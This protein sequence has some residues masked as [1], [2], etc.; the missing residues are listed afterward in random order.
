[1]NKIK[2]IIHTA[3]WHLEPSSYHD[4]FEEA[5]DTFMESIAYN[6]EG[7]SPDEIL[8]VIVGDLFDNKSKKQTNEAVD[9]MSKALNKISQI[10]RTV[11]T[12][13]NHDYDRRNKSSMDC[14]SPIT[15]SFKMLG[16]SNVEYLKK[17]KHYIYENICFFNFSN[18]DDNAAPDIK[19]ISK[20]YPN[21]TY[22]GLYHD[23]LVGATNFQNM[24]VSEY[25]GEAGSLSIFNGCDFVLLGD[26]HKHQK[27][28]SGIPIVYSGSLYQLNMG[29]NV[30]GHGYCIWD[31]ED[32]TFEFIE[33]DIEWGKYKMQMSSFGDIDL[34]NEIIINK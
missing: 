34:N 5:I 13:G 3:D 4:R 17:T 29:E 8:V 32:K 7:Y 20:L 27:L 31:V 28:G 10:Y 11:I 1:M 23:I 33:V 9:V 25:H 21:K 19:N 24:D 15:N 14:I 30:N 18:F 26:I 6:T 2:K 16:N 12:I 22:V